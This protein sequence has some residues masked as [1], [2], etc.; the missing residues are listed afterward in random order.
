LVQE[1]SVVSDG[2]RDAFSRWDDNEAAN[3]RN[4]LLAS[5]LTLT[6]IF[7]QQYLLQL[8][9]PFPVTGEGWYDADT[10]TT[11]AVTQPIVDHGNGTRHLFVNWSGDAVGSGDQMLVPM[12]GPKRVVA[13]WKLQY[14]LNI[15]SEWG[16]PSGGGWYDAYASAYVSV[17]PVVECACMPGERRVFTGWG[18]LQEPTS[19][20]SVTVTMTG[21]LSLRAYWKTQHLVQVAVV[22]ANAQPVLEPP[23]TVTFSSGLSLLAN[24]SAVWVDSG[25]Y[26]IAAIAWHGVNV[27]TSNTDHLTGPNAVWRI[28]SRI[29][30]V[31]LSV[32]SIL[33]GLPV[34]GATLTIKLPDGETLSADAAEGVVVFEQLP[35][36]TYDA[37][38]STFPAITQVIHLTVDGDL[39]LSA[40]VPVFW[41]FAAILSISIL[42][43][44]FAYEVL[45]IRKHARERWTRL[46]G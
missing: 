45:Q 17:E 10:T 22:D 28:P 39:S 41:E 16:N 46:P 27:T 14:L 13:N 25:S 4:I 23:A 20:P 32:R 30:K 19:S 42:C 26:S 37:I 6:A 29:Y 5:D 7:K 1:Y 34:N 2:V 36:G 35:A 3:P 18:G 9:S 11:I 21:P 8:P 43:I 44:V 38:L 12:S 24:G 15:E 33:T 40:A 31:E